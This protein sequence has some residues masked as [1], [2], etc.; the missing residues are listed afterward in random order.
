MPN[1]V[2]RVAPIVEDVAAQGHQ[3]VDGADHA[4][5]EAVEEAPPDVQAGNRGSIFSRLGTPPACTTL[6]SPVPSTLMSM[7]DS[8][9]TENQMGTDASTVL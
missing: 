1:A 9:R 4:A 5:A 7:E 6:P 2:T 8:S 3:F